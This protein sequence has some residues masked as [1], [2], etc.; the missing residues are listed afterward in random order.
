MYN[1][2]KVRPQVDFSQ[3]HL[4]FCKADSIYKPII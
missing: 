1:D 4:P 3:K 2:L